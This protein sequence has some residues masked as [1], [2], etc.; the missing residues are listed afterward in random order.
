MPEAK[1][2][3]KLFTESFETIPE[4]S[5]YP[6]RNSALASFGG[7]TSHTLHTWFSALQSGRKKAGLCFASAHSS[8]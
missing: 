2:L 5:Q 3:E 6:D 8:G 4:Q 7:S 1:T